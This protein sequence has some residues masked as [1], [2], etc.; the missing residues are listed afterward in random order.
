MKEVNKPITTPETDLIRLLFAPGIAPDYCPWNPSDTDAESYYQSKE[1]AFGLDDWS[2][3]DLQQSAH[4]FFA[5]LNTC[6]PDEALDVLALL[7]QK[8]AA[9]IPQQWLEKVAAEATKAA[10]EKVA[11]VDQLVTC[12]QNLLPA[13]EA[14]DLLVFARPYSYAMRSDPSAFSVDNLA[15]SIEWEE[16]SATEQV[17]LTMMVSKFALEQLNQD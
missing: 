5:K 16:L 11:A 13:W 17:K 3:E 2:A 4:S 9:R 12:V 1:Q 6:W 8:F 7:C 14:E 15:R 10:A